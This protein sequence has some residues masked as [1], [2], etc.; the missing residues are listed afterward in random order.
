M[1]LSCFELEDAGGVKGGEV[2]VGRGEAAGA[3]ELKEGAGGAEGEIFVAGGDLA[4]EDAEGFS[5][6]GAEGSAAAPQI[7]WRRRLSSA[8]KTWL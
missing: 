6:G 5:E 8:W 3:G 4:V 1:D 2:G 7:S